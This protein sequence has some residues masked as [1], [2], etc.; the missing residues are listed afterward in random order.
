MK[1][2]INLTPGN[3]GPHYFTFD[4]N[5]E[6]D[7]RLLKS[8]AGENDFPIAP[9]GGTFSVNAPNKTITLSAGHTFSGQYIIY[10]NTSH[11]TRN[12]FYPSGAI[13]ADDLNK[14]FEQVMYAAEDKVPL[15]N[16]VMEDNLD[17]G[18]HRITNLKGTFTGQNLE[19]GAIDSYDD[20]DAASI[21]F[22]KHFF[23]DSGAETVLS[24]ETWE[25]NNTTI[26]TTAAADSRIN[27]RLSTALTDNVLETTDNNYTP[28]QVDDL[29]TAT[30]NLEQISL[31]LRD[32]NLDIINK[33]VPEQL[34]T[35]TKTADVIGS[36]SNDGV[37]AT[38]AAIKQRHDTVMSATTPN[39]ADYAVGTFWY[40]NSG[41]ASVT[42]SEGVNQNPEQDI[43]ALYVLNDANGTKEWIGIA[44]G[45]TWLNQSK[46]IWVDAGNGDDRND[47]HRVIRPMKT[48]QGAINRSEDGDIIFVQPGVYKEMLPLDLGP[49]QN[50][51]IRGLGMRSVF[52]HP[53]PQN[54]FTGAQLPNTQSGTDSEKTFIVDSNGVMTGGPLGQKVSGSSEELIMFKCG[55][56]TFVSDLTVA[57]M[58]ASGTRGN[59]TIDAGPTGLSGLTSGEQASDFGLP[60]NQGWF[61]AFSD[62]RLEAGA[63]GSN[64]EDSKV[65]FHKSP[66]I[67]N[68]TCFADSGIDN[69][70]FDPDNPLNGGFAGDTTSSMTGGGLFVDGSV[71]HSDSP[72]KSMLTD[73][74]TFIC[75]DGP[76]ALVTNGGYAQLVSTFGT[77]CHYHA[78]AKNGGQINMS[79]CTTDFGRY[80]L[81]T[82]DKGNAVAI[83][84]GTVG[85]HEIGETEID[86]LVDSTETFR[87]QLSAAK[88]IDHMVV[89]YSVGNDT[90]THKISKTVGSVNSN[91]DGEY[92]VTLATPLTVQLSANHTLNF[93]LQ[94]LISTGGHVFEFAGSGTDYNAHPDNGGQPNETNQ[95][96]NFG[97]GKVYISSTDHNA[98]FKVGDVLSVDDDSSTVA[99]T[100][101]LTYNGTLLTQNALVD[102]TNADNISS[103]TLS[104]DRLGV[105]DANN[106]P[107]LNADKINDG[108]LGVDRIPNLNADK[109]NDGTLNDDRLSNAYDDNAD[110]DTDDSNANTFEYSNPTIR[111]DAKGRV[112]A[113]KGGSAAVSSVSVTAPITDSGTATVP[114]IGVSTFTA[115]TSSSG[116]NSGIVPG[117]TAGDQNKFL[118]GDTNFVDINLGSTSVTNGVKVSLNHDTTEYDSVTL[119]EGSNI[120]LAES[121]GEITINAPSTNIANVHTQEYPPGSPQAGQIW[122][123]RGTGESYI[124]YNDGDSSQWVMLAPQQRGTGNGTVQQVSGTANNITVDNSVSG[125]SSYT[126][127]LADV[128]V[129]ATTSYTYG[130]ATE[131]AQFN[132]DT[133]G[134]VHQAANITITPDISNV[135]V[136]GTNIWDSENSKFYVQ[137]VPLPS[138]SNNDLPAINLSN[139]VDTSTTLSSGLISYDQTTVTPTQIQV[140]SRSDFEDAGPAEVTI[141][142]SNAQNYLSVG[143]TFT[144]SSVVLSSNTDIQNLLNATHEVKAT[145]SNGITIEIGTSSN[146]FFDQIYTIQNTDVGS[147]T[148][149]NKL[150]PNLI[151]SFNAQRLEG[152]IPTSAVPNGVDASKIST[153][154]L[155]TTVIPANLPYLANVSDDTAPSLNSGASNFNVSGVPINTSETNNITFQPGFTNSATGTGNGIIQVLGNDSPAKI[156]LFAEDTSTKTDRQFGAITGTSRSISVTVPGVSTLTNSYTLTL[157]PEPADANNKFLKVSSISNNVVVTEWANDRYQAAQQIN[158]MGGVSRTVN[159]DEVPTY[160]A[161]SE[162]TVPAPGVNDHG[163]YLESSGNWSFPVPTGMIMWWPR[164]P[165]VANNV[166]TSN[167][168]SGWIQCKGQHLRIKDSNGNNTIW[169]A[170]AEILQDPLDGLD[171]NNEG[172]LYASH[173]ADT[174]AWNAITDKH[175]YIV[176]PDLRGEFIRGWDRDAETET[177]GRG[178]DSGRDLGSAQGDQ[179]EKH[180]HYY[181]KGGASQSQALHV[182]GFGGNGQ[183]GSDAMTGDGTD[184]KRIATSAVGTFGD[185]T[186]PRNVALIGII[187]I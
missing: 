20:G 133:K 158:S 9:A 104:N 163:K 168:P 75:L 84:S 30:N 113:A 135:K 17:M 106:I 146:A 178:V 37:I 25:S 161:G 144:L 162:G 55:S 125:Q 131:S 15:V 41:E 96:R 116:G 107:N 88:P 164:M 5:D 105:L 183:S 45:G 100:G 95:V 166:V 87:N 94:S 59:S 174:T 1:D 35:S 13:R 11:D 118:R 108:T 39:P 56:G 137:Y 65:K 76:G 110:P 120:T 115:A 101:N 121:N 48:L 43:R 159:S 143:D 176:L 153:G 172:G 68:C 165:S 155:P 69:S 23:F 10:R 49:R 58:K 152:T 66:Y 63:T 99:V 44:S 3:V 92:T 167:I 21:G 86:I 34:L 32:G 24:N 61:F 42:D 71:P 64:A 89:S 91:G 60:Q 103:G 77:F 117:P 156:S 175:N 8:D 19:D 109:I 132:V 123:D 54:N 72:L 7:V 98:K 141:S 154:T 78:K 119:K 73:A 130:S 187:K 122:W 38:I 129:A 40:D 134:R 180:N 2:L 149:T 173:V 29:P 67:Q 53:D 6:D 147:L 90:Y 114:N 93:Y 151:P 83:T 47:G 177:T 36:W 142:A 46:L 22:V 79:N 182:A 12:T 51:T 97:D 14:N 112:I 179:L 136:S 160:T 33:V 52:I 28:I 62:N 85:T 82:E 81:I 18:G 127:D 26:T 70:N 31:G 4:I 80:G 148:Y 169:Y 128:T 111:I 74:Y 157:P 139:G 181:F 57:G 150:D 124:Y 138:I 170:L 140:E 27:S 102:T 171:G 126:L 186:R 50:V 184:S 145:A 16:P 185:E